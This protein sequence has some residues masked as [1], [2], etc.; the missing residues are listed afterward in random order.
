MVCVSELFCELLFL[1][2]FTEAEPEL[3]FLVVVDFL[4]V[5]SSPDE[6]EGADEYIG[7]PYPIMELILL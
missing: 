6:S 5:C 1:L 2:E 7:T 3:L 4:V